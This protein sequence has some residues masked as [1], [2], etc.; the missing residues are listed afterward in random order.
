MAILVGGHVFHL[1]ELESAHAGMAMHV[2][3]CILAEASPFWPS[4]SSC[5]GAMVTISHSILIQYQD[6]KAITVPSDMVMKHGEDDYIRLRPTNYAVIQLICGSSSC[7]ASISS[8]RKLHELIRMRNEQL[9]EGHEHEDSHETLFAP[10][11]PEASSSAK[12]APLKR[13]K[14]MKILP[15]TINIMVKGVQVQCLVHGRRPV[16]SDLAIRIDAEQIQAVVEYMREDAIEAMQ[17]SKRKYIKKK[18]S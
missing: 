2:L 6:E 18:R 11:E 17:A 10:Q 13:K 14:T 1:C 16:A 15:E 3:V 12:D 4:T 9:M 5:C 8:S 7:N